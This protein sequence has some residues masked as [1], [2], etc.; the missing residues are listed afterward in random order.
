[1]KAKKKKK[2][3]MVIGLDRF[4]KSVAKSLEANGCMVLA[5]DKD[6]KKI[7]QIADYVTSAM[8]LDITDEEAIEELGINNFDGAIISFANN[9]EGAV[10]ATVCLKDRGIPCVIAEAYDN[11]QGKVLKKVGVDRIIYSEQ[12]MGVHLANNLAFDHFIDTVELS[13]EYTIAE[14]QTPAS[15]VGKSL[16]ELNLRKKYDVNVI[17]HK[18]NNETDITPIADMPLLKDD[19]LVIL[20][21]NNTIKKLSDII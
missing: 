19:V 5:I 21:K 6:Q 16:I 1:M 14:I 18:R 11:S 9:L 7:N 15:W 13:S 3:Y 20:G 4:G 2:Q 17:A 8:C 10:L 12:E